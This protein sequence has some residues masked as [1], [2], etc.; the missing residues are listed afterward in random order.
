MENLYLILHVVYKLTPVFKASEK[1]QLL[2]HNYVLCTEKNG[3]FT[4]RVLISLSPKVNERLLG[5]YFIVSFPLPA[6]CEDNT[7]Q[8]RGDMKRAWRYSLYHLN[9]QYKAL[10]TSISIICNKWGKF[11][12][13]L[14][15]WFQHSIVRRPKMPPTYPYR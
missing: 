7:S 1:H 12:R 9:N 2:F 15:R 13:I 6:T 14:A 5:D 3:L 10:F 11:R 8:I 4:N